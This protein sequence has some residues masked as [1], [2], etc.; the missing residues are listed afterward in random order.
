MSQEKVVRERQQ[1]G[2]Q[3][4]VMYKKLQFK[5]EQAISKD[6]KSKITFQS[7]KYSF[8]VLKKPKSWAELAC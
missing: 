3:H 4:I 5:S 1:K 7:V 8:T 6:Q 2:I